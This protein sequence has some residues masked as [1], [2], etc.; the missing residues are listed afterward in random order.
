MDAHGARAPAF[1]LDEAL[2]IGLLPL[3]ANAPGPA[4]TLNAYATLYLEQEVRA[5]GMTRNVAAFARFWKRRASRIGL[6]PS[7][8]RRERSDLPPLG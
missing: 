2:R 1:S 7:G 6:A 8:A 4:A 3:V 5:E